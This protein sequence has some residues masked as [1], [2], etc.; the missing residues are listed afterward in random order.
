MML[1][2]MEHGAWGKEQGEKKRGNGK[3]GYQGVCR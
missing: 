1:G 3:R 2:S